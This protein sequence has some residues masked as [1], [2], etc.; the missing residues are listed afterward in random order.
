MI[1]VLWDIFE[2]QWK[3]RNDILHGDE[4]Q[5]SELDTNRKTDRLLEFREHKRTMLRRCDHS[6]IDHP[7][8]DVIKRSRNH[9]IKVLQNLERLK[10]IYDKELKTETS[11]LRPITNYFLP[12]R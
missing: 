9:K 3:C 4:S 6:M 2:A 11:R 10:K 8:A 1:R 12:V 7:I 5:T